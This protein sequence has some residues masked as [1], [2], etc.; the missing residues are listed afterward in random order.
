MKNVL[1]LEVNQTRLCFVYDHLSGNIDVKESSIKGKTIKSFNNKTPL[2]EVKSFFESLQ[3]STAN[4][5]LKI[6]QLI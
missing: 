2:E 1:W 4:V 6:K 5:N 3:N